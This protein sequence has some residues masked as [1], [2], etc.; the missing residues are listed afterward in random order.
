[1]LPEPLGLSKVFYTFGSPEV[2]LRET[3]LDAGMTLP[4]PN[5]KVGHARLLFFLKKKKTNV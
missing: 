1:M 4:K 3:S 5:R 2:R